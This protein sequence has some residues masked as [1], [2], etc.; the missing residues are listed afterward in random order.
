MSSFK[1]KPLSQGKEANISHHSEEKKVLPLKKENNLRKMSIRVNPA[2]LTKLATPILQKVLSYLGVPEV[3]Y[4]S[5]S[6]F[7]LFRQLDL[8]SLDLSFV[9]LNYEVFAEV[10]TGTSIP[11]T[12]LYLILS[13]SGISA[14]MPFFPK[15]KTL[16]AENTSK[17]LSGYQVSFTVNFLSQCKELT[18]FTLGAGITVEDISRLGFCNKLT[19]LAFSDCTIDMGTEAVAQCKNLVSLK[20]HGVGKI[21][22]FLLALPQLPKLKILDIYGDC[23][24]SICPSI[25]RCSTLEEVYLR[26]ITTL[27]NLDFLQDNSNLRKIVLS[28]NSTALDFS[29]LATCPNLAFF[30]YGGFVGYPDEIDFSCL[31]LLSRLNT[32][33]IKDCFLST[34]FTLESCSALL[35]LKLSN[36][37]GDLLI[38]PFP[39]VKKREDG[40]FS[41]LRI[42]HLLESKV[43]NLSSLANVG[44]LTEVVILDCNKLIN[45]NFLG[46]CPLLEKLNIEAPLT[47]FDFLKPYS[48]IR[49]LSSTSKVK[50]IS[51]VST[52]ISLHINSI[53]TKET[54]LSPTSTEVKINFESNKTSETTLAGVNIHL[55]SKKTKRVKYSLPLKELTISGWQISNLYSLRKCRSLTSLTVRNCYSLRS[56]E[57]LGQCKELT[58]LSVRGENLSHI[59]AVKYLPKLEIFKL[60]EVDLDIKL[61]S[62][63]KCS[64]LKELYFSNISGPR[65][66][67]LVHCRTLEILRIDCANILTCLSDLQNSLGLRKLSIRSSSVSDISPLSRLTNLEEVSLV[68]FTQLE[69]IEPLGKL[70]KLHFLNLSD[71]TK[72]KSLEPLACCENLVEFVYTVTE[73]IPEGIKIQGVNT[74]RL[75][76][77]PLVKCPYLK[78]IVSTGNMILKNADSFR[79]QV[80]ENFKVFVRNNREFRR[81]DGKW[82]LK[83]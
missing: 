57:G 60:G 75:D 37:G 52:E 22:G 19:H 24:T 73:V 48:S 8:L 63:R 11:L 55:S 38:P 18:T 69:D 83:E 61:K 29:A 81:K 23:N 77:L 21:K 28:E 7:S 31:S 74:P 53:E 9:P 27:M 62:L 47:V 64:K 35:E 56:L 82:Y 40:S 43:E 58:S 68:K 36:I 76:L 54:K 49:S 34:D 15:L 1:I 78:K 20:I 12:G 79:N 67:F 4:L 14:L 46:A 25:G 30:H 42:F 26:N 32:L 17:K 59:E 50:K 72:I 65:L 2:P 16:K 51:S 66:S 80:G 39:A 70:R 3:S 45:A 71:S 41:G 44:Q 13:R 33:I 10:F 6:C 5:P